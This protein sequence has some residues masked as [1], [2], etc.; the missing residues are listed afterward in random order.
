MIIEEEFMVD[1]K[2]PGWARIHGVVF[3]RDAGGERTAIL[4]CESRFGAVSGRLWRS[5]NYLLVSCYV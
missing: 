2:V 5:G 3:E 4:S 1:G